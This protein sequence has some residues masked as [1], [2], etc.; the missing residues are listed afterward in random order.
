[1]TPTTPPAAPGY[2][3]RGS[4]DPLYPGSLRGDYALDGFVVEGKPEEA[5]FVVRPESPEGYFEVQ[6][7]LVGRGGQVENWGPAAVRRIE[8]RTTADRDAE[9]TFVFARHLAHDLPQRRTPEEATRELRYRAALAG[10]AP[11]SAAAEEYVARNLE[12][13]PPELPSSPAPAVRRVRR[14]AAAG[15]GQ[16]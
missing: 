4:L 16:P 15:G 8:R 1:M 6:I 5:K 13:D 14:V 7:R 2:P 9:V 10:M 12:P 11:G 3:A